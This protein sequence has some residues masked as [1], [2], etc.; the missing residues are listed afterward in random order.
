MA[1][2]ENTNSRVPASD[3][4]VTGWSREEERIAHRGHKLEGTVRGNASGKE[5][6]L[7]ALLLPIP[8]CGGRVGGDIHASLDGGAGG[9]LSH[10]R[11]GAVRRS[12]DV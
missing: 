2:A 9:G 8:C 1:R 4:R 3:A 11:R 12:A 7:L 6:A 10:V 5:G